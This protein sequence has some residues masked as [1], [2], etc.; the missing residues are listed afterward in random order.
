MS[1]EAKT[2]AMRMLERAKVSYQSHEYPHEEGTAVD[3]ASVARLTGQDPAR[4]FKTLVTQGA[5][6]AFYVFVIPVLAELD[7]KKAARSVGVKSVAMIHVADINRV[8]GYIRG[9]CS[10]V[11]MKKQFVT[12]FDESCLAQPTMLVSGGRIGTQIECAPADL[13]RVTRGK[14]AAITAGG[15]A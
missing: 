6:K 11:G 2:N 5:D 3:G 13:L 15:D 12:V 10:P 1:K 14:T 8:T 4:V 9:G 7:L